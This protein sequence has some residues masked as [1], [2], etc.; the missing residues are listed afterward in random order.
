MTPWMSNLEI[1]TIEKFLNPEMTML[2]YGSGGSTAHFS[3][4]VRYYYSLEHDGAWYRTVR[5]RVGANTNLF[6]VMIKNCDIPGSTPPIAK[7]WAELES[8]CRYKIFE[9]YIKYPANWGI[10]FDA[11]LIDGRARPECAKFIYDYLNKGAHVFIHDYWSRPKYHVV[12]EAY[13]VVD[14]VKDGQTLVVLKKK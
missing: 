13:D 5:N 7:S 2:E 8:S 4:K 11:V 6:H 14:S 10:K 9:K 12:E 1:K 3:T